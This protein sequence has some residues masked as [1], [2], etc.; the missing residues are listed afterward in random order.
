MENNKE[1]LL[2]EDLLNAK[3][4]LYKG[5]DFCTSRELLESFFEFTSGL[6]YFK[7]YIIKVDKQVQNKNDDGTLNTSFGRAFITALLNEEK[8][9]E[10][11]SFGLTYQLDRPK[12]IA[13]L[14]SLIHI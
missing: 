7:E 1:T 2:P 4:Y 10:P 6:P 11:M 14:L 9:G 3:T 8:K 12:P 5:K 13:T